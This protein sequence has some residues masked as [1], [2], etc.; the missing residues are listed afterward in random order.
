MIWYTHLFCPHP[1]IASVYYININTVAI[2]KIMRPVGKVMG[3]HS[4]SS[5]KKKMLHKHTQLAVLE[6]SW[7]LMT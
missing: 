6:K 3:G 2:I 4:Q 1:L 7:A 5:Q